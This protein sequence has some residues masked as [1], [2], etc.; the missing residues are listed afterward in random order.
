[1]G[2][3]CLVFDWGQ[4]S[5]AILSSTPVVGAFDPVHDGR[6]E[7]VSGGPEVPVEDVVLQVSSPGFSR[8][9]LSGVDEVVDGFK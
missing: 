6:A 5:K 4:S 2:H 3:D 7:F 1:M 9:W 8:G